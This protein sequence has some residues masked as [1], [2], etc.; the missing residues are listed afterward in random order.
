VEEIDSDEMIEKKLSEV[1]DDDFEM[2]DLVEEY[3]EDSG[4]EL[5]E[6]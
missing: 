6:E 3:D 4:V 1:M 5:E 2:D